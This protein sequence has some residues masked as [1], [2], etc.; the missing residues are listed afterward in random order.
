MASSFD[1]S[2]F[3]HEIVEEGYHVFSLTNAKTPGYYPNQFPDYPGVKLS[4]LLVGDQITVRVF[5]LVGSGENVRADGGYIDLE[6]EVVE[7]DHIIGRILTKLPKHFALETGT[8]LE[9]R[10]DEILHKIKSTQV[11]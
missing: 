10:E 4:S 8:S 1:E 5:F 11:H 7:T 9:I 3:F 6:V 2:P